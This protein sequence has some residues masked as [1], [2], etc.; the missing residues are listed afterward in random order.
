MILPITSVFAILC[1]IMLAALTFP[2]VFQR[3]R[4]KISLGFHGDAVLERRVR[5]HANF[6][7]Y[8]PFAL[9]LIG[10]IEANG[11]PFWLVA[12][13]AILFLIG[14]ILHA[15]GIY[16]GQL[17]PRASGMVLTILTLTIASGFLLYCLL[18]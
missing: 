3:K 2:V 15:A 10:L 9:I 5:A 4:A 7:E 12:V 6:C 1:A 18:G 14:R 13:C 16:T 17:P 11:A 8:A